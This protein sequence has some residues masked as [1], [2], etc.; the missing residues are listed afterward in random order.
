MLELEHY[1]SIHLM[2]IAAVGYRTTKEA[3]LQRFGVGT[4]TVATFLQ[5]VWV[6]KL[7][8]KMLALIGLVHENETERMLVTN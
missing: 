8:K 4:A 5:H 7:L 6:Y 2:L 1:E 3:L